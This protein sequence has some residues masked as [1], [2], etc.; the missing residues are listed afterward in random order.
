MA[1]MVLW[2]MAAG[3]AASSMRGDGVPD[4]KMPVAV[5][6]STGSIPARIDID[7]R[8][9]AGSQIVAD[10][11]AIEITQLTI[12]TFGLVEGDIT[13]M[14]LAEDPTNGDVYDNIGDKIV[15][16]RGNRK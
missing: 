12:E 15:L 10:L 2:P 9:D 1:W 16:I 6:P 13:E 14:T 11:T 3:G 8:R 4:S 5:Q 7:A